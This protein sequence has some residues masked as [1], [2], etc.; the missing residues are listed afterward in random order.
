MAL[1]QLN[2]KAICILSALGSVREAVLLQP[3][4]VILNHKVWP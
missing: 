3:S 1:S 4:G 2:S